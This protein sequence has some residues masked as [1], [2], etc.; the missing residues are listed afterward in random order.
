VAAGTVP[1]TIV[2]GTEAPPPLIPAEQTTGAGVGRDSAMGGADELLPHPVRPIIMTDRS[3]LI[4][5]FRFPFGSEKCEMLGAAWR[6][7]D[8]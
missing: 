1:V 4:D 5:I 2:I 6:R 8:R 3:P 7:D